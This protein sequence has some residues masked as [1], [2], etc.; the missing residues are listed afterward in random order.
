MLVRQVAPAGLSAAVNGSQLDCVLALFESG[1]ASAVNVAGKDRRGIFKT[2]RQPTM[3]LSAPWRGWRLLVTL[4]VSVRHE[5]SHDVGSGFRG[6][7]PPAPNVA[8]PGHGTGRGA[9]T[10]VCRPSYSLS[11]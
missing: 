4:Q 11:I 9:G 6:K 5:N 3:L 8:A 1:V 7:P 10:K 2:S